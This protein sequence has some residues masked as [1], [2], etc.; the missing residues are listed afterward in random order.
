MVKKITLLFS[1][2]NA[3]YHYLHAQDNRFSGW[4]MYVHTI[5]I[6]KNISSHLDVQLRS[7]D[8]VKNVETFIFRPGVNYQFKNK[9]IATAGYAL[10]EG[11]RTISGDR[12]AVAEHR[13]WQQYI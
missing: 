7:D 10:I 12:G 2:F 4:S 8:Q 9:T 13:I 5:K 11:W 1:L 3:S 6:T